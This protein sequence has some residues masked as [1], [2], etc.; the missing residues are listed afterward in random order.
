MRHVIRTII[1]AG[2]LLGL[3]G[4]GGREAHGATATPCTVA[5]KGTT[6]NTKLGVAAAPFRISCAGSWQA[7]EG[8]QWWADT[9]RGKWS[10][11]GTRYVY[12]SGTRLV[13]AWDRPYHGCGFWRTLVTLKGVSYTS[14][15]EWFCA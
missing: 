6:T 15:A 9:G 3:A 11:G 4:P 8:V 10:F 13:A 5:W 12:G 14:R 1:V 7:F 2:L